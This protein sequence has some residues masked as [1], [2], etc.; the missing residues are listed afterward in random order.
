MIRQTGITARWYG[1]AANRFLFL[2]TAL[3]ALIFFYPFVEEFDRNGYIFPVL[4]NIIL[5]LALYAV[6]DRNQH[7]RIALILLLPAMCMLWARA[8]FGMIPEVIVGSA[9]TSALFFSVIIAIIVHRILTTRHVNRD[10]I[11]GA[12]CVYLLIGLLWASMYAAAAEMS[13]AAFSYTPDITMSGNSLTFG[14]LLYFSFITLTTT[15]YGDIIPTMRV[16]QSLAMVEA[17][18]GVIFLAVF[19]S[20]LVGIVGWDTASEEE[21]RK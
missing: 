17:I 2:L 1:S 12:V 14:D 8:V 21:E 20:R 11:Y 13:P 9:L 10:T 5:F 16:T 3:I 19:V 15:G 7:F 6:I 18:T 4:M